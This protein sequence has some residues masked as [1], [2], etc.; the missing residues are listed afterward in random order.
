MVPVPPRLPP[1]VA[2]MLEPLLPRLKREIEAR[3]AELRPLVAEG[4]RLVAAK[5]AMLADAAAESSARRHVERVLPSR[6]GAA[7]DSTAPPRPR[8]RPPPGDRTTRA[9]TAARRAARTRP[10]SSRSS[11]SG[12]RV[13]RRDRRRHED[14]EADGRDDRLE[15]QAR[16]PAR[17]RGGRREARLAP[18]GDACR[19]R[20]RRARSA[21][22]A[23]ATRSGRRRA[24]ATRRPRSGRVHSTPP[25]A[26]PSATAASPSNRLP[27]RLTTSARSLW[28]SARRSLSSIQV[29]KVV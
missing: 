16:G 13:R 14:R 21:T 27:A 3:L 25:S 24:A 17:R 6:N 5:Q 26:R 2:P 12:R 18:A 7:H 10:R 11:R 9:R 1:E 23:S 15:A 4:E 28:C 22:R 20:R 8:R 29:E 19:R